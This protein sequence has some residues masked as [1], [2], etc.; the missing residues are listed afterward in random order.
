MYAIESFTYMFLFVLFID[1]TLKEKTQINIF[2]IKSSL[3]FFV[4]YA[5]QEAYNSDWFQ[6][7]SKG[8]LLLSEGI[9]IKN[10]WEF[11]FFYI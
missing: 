1:L 2:G 7:G 5:G 3:S 9:G 6:Y 10:R 4:S 11:L 8:N